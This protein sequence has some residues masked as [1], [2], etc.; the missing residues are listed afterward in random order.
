[1]ALTGIASLQPWLQ[2]YA[3]Y[4]VDWMRLSSGGRYDV[5]GNI[6]GGVVPTITSGTRSLAKQAELYANRAK[7]PYPVN[8]PG[9]SAHNFGL[10][11]DSDVPDEW[12][13][14]WIEIRRLVGFRVPENDEVHAE[15]PNWR[16]L[17]QTRS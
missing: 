8:K 4:A 14:L 6:T 15:V 5:K 13:P 7:N 12:M 3:Y 9:D 17:V 10:G 1:M 16:S 2:P 11:F